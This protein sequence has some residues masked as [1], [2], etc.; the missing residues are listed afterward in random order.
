M[1]RRRQTHTPAT[2]AAPPLQRTLARA[3]EAEALLE[4]RA[5]AA[6]PQ[7]A[8]QAAVWERHVSTNRMMA[9]VRGAEAAF[10]LPLERHSCCGGGPS[11]VCRSV[12]E[13]RR[14]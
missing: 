8:A 7:S 13:V 1:P 6:S 14:R 2:P 11:V 3:T 5:A 9:Q 4:R 10:G 12:L